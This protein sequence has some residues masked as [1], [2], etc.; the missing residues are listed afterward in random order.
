MNTFT[1]GD[2]TAQWIRPWTPDHKVHGSNLLTLAIAFLDMA[3]FLH[4][5]VPLRGLKIICSLAYLQ[6]VCSLLVMEKLSQNLIN[7]IQ[8]QYIVS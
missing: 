2:V 1:P 3:L 8:I 4:C 5:L 7:S 6:A